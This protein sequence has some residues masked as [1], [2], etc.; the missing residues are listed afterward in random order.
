M[1]LNVNCYL[2]FHIFISSTLSTNLVNSLKA[3]VSLV[4][5]TLKRK[6]L[7]I[8]YFNGQLILFNRTIKTF[9]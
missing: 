8:Q 6:Q 9:K 5:F 1:T 3:K 4:V 7:S 2:M